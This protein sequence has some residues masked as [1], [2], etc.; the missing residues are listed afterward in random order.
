MPFRS[1]TGNV[2]SRAHSAEDKA[3]VRQAFIDTGRRLIGEEG[4][5]NVSL[6][7]IAAEA[8]YSPGTIYQYFRDHRELLFA[9][10]EFD[11]DAA[12]DTIEQFGA[13]EMDPPKRLRKLFVGSVKYWVSHL[14]DFELLFAGPVHVRKGSA[15]FG[16]SATVARS[17]A[18]YRRAVDDFLVSLPR[19]PLP[20]VLA[21]DI[22]IATSHGIVAF[23]RLTR[24]M[25][26][27]DT[28]EMAEKAIDALIQTWSIAGG[29]PL[30]SA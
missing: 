17:A 9:I 21:T 6:R 10:R 27:S 25:K 3:K 14:D 20:T 1:P 28:V 16:E 19:R 4:A 15:P 26:W 12:T 11:M 8:G 23:P 5:E 24:T 7:R 22:L 30:A 18:M 29:K 2:R 13:G